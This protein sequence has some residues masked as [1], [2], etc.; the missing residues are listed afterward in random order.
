[1]TI[2]LRL[3]VLLL[4]IIQYPYIVSFHNQHIVHT[5]N[6]YCNIYCY[7]NNN[8]N[9]NNNNH[10]IYNNNN[11]NN[12]NNNKRYQNL[13]MSSNSNSDINKPSI[14]IILSD[15]KKKFKRKISNEK[16]NRNTNSD[17]NS[18]ISNITSDIVTAIINNRTSSMI[19][20]SAIL[21]PVI[22]ITNIYYYYN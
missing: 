4:V 14:K 16:I 11:N 12:N 19:T 15:D 6:I 9:N 8:I 7:N 10:H 2:Y 3:L 17:S 13:W 1:M 5:C 18:S 20:N 22:L 21:R